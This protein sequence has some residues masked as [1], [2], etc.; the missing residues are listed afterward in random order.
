MAHRK[1]SVYLDKKIWK[2][3]ILLIPET[4]SFYVGYTSQ[5]D[6]LSTYK[7]HYNLEIARTSPTISDA[8]TSGHHIEMYY[9]DTVEAT[10]RDVFFY[11]VVWAKRLMDAGYTCFNGDGFTVH[12]KEFL[13]EMDTYND[14][15]QSKSLTELLDNSRSLYPDYGRKSAQAVPQSTGSRQ[16]KRAQV[17]YTVT[18]DEYSRLAGRAVAR[19]MMP[20]AIAKRL[21]LDTTPLTLD[22]SF[23]I[24][25]HNEVDE[26]LTTLKN[27]LYTIYKTQ[28]Y[29]AQDIALIRELGER[30]NKNIVNSMDAFANA[31]DDVKKLRK[32]RFLDSDPSYIHLPQKFREYIKE[33]V[34]ADLEKIHGEEFEESIEE[35]FIKQ[36]DKDFDLDDL[37]AMAI[38][39]NRRRRIDLAKTLIRKLDRSSDAEDKLKM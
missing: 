24:D 1:N 21:A 31:L 34:E 30:V 23:I 33:L 38:K 9:L 18:Q 13:P 39:D 12:T 20:N 32:A 2:L 4:L 11:S 10:K 26:C 25:Y 15:I 8:K 14:Q 3:Y 16:S 19:G 5:S 27:V 36:P 17:S 29:N 35:A 6:L 7:H 37:T 28:M 22:T